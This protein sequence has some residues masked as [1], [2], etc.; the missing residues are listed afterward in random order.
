MKS[1]LALSKEA[2]EVDVFTEY[3][4]KASLYQSAKAL[5]LR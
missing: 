5:N 4:Q 1:I 2:G 3:F